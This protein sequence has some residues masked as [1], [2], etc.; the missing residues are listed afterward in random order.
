LQT[1]CSKIGSS[2]NI[3]LLNIEYWI[4]KATG[5]QGQCKKSFGLLFLG[6]WILGS[7]DTAACVLG[8]CLED[9]KIVHFNQ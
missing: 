2:F 7:R 9:K 6:G 8:M 4:L 5:K 1:F 3:F